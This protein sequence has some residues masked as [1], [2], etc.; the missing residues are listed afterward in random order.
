MP[1]KDP[2]G[3]KDW[4]RRNAERVRARS[5]ARYRAHVAVLKS[6]ISRWKARH[7]SKVAEHRATYCATRRL[8]INVSPERIDP[9]SVF[10]QDEWTCQMCFT[11]TPP[12]LRGKRAAHAPQL[13]HV[14]PLAM[15]GPHV[16]WN[17]QTLCF[18]CNASKG[19][20]LV[21]CEAMGRCEVSRF[22]AQLFLSG[23]S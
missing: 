17:V 5:A 12:A 21:V 4:Y 16:R 3:F 23:P 7:P 14:I 6:Q 11:Y 13:D 18:E 15:G 2:R 20:R 19:A 1:Y 9:N 8:R 22:L 10:A